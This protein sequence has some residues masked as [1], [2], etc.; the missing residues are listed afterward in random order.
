MKATLKKTFS[1]LFCL[2]FLFLAGFLLVGCNETET[3]DYIT[4][5]SDASFTN[6]QDVKFYN[7]S[8]LTITYQGNNHYTIEGSASIMTEE[9]ATA[10]ST[11][12]GVSV[13]NGALYIVLNV[14]TGKGATEVVGWRSEEEKDVAFTEGEIGINYVTTATSA[15]ETK[16]FILVIHS[17]VNFLHENAQIWRIEVTTAVEEGET[18]ETVVYTVDFSDLYNV[19]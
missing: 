12:T 8:D 10:Y 15:N 7:S 2:V 9:Q 17:G 14:K 5:G 11:E 1:I 4:V 6:Y 3:N 18:T 13:G 16:N 19:N